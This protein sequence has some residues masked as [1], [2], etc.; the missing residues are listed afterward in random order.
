MTVRRGEGG[1]GGLAPFG[2]QTT[3]AIDRYLRARRTHRLAE[4]PPLWLG[5]R[6]KSLEYYGL[7]SA[8]KISP[9]VGR[10]AELHPHLLRAA[11]PRRGSWPRAA[12]GAV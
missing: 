5:D 3:R 4:T 2:D 8:L 1:K 12:L 10:P 6:G 11:P 7:H 9:P